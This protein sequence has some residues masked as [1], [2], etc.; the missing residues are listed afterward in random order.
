[1]DIWVI[2]TLPEI[3][4]RAQAEATLDAVVV[5]PLRSTGGRITAKVLPPSSSAGL[6]PIGGQ[7]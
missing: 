3:H 7:A 6:R 1:M 2:F 4:N 5:K